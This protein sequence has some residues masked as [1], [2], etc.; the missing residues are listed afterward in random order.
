MI[1]RLII[2]ELRL[3][4]ERE[5]RKPLILRGAR[6]VGKTTLVNEFSKEYGVFLKLNLEIADD[7]NLFERYDKIEELLQAIYVYNHQI[8]EELP[9]L[10]FIDEIQNSP[11]AVAMLRYFNE[12]ANQIHV[13]AAGSLLESLLN[14]QRISFPVGRV[15]YMAM[16]P[17]N[18]LEF[19]NG[20]GEKFDADLIQTI[21]VNAVHER[22]MHLFNSYTLVGGMP[23]AVVQYALNRDI[24]SVAT[25]YE[26][27]LESYREDAEK[28][29]LNDTSEKVIRH[30]LKTGWGSA[31]ETISF[32][33]FGGSNYRSREMGTAF[34]ILE[35]ALLVELVYPT[36]ETKLPILVD[37]RKKP[38][39]IWL[40]TGLVNY[41][42]K[43]QQEV[44]SAPNIQDVWRGRIAEHIVA[45][46][47]LTLD[48]RI[49][50]T[51]NYW[52][53]NKEGSEAEVDF[54]Y[55]Y[56]GKVIPIEIKSGHNARLRS[57]HTFMEHAPHNIA[58][59]VWSQ[60]LSLDIVKTPQGK[61]FKLI[62][63]PFYYIGVLEKVLEKF[64]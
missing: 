5:N 14:T 53:R 56:K 26:S 10:L 59:R 4:K 47:L 8:V 29:A 16:R 40:D 39:I 27:L 15:E 28:Y 61:E 34:R 30:I 38:K 63:L 2:K 25:I 48:T 51:R 32:E 7:R 11:K 6:Q 12:G 21:Q 18:F 24:L 44:F 19:L 50:V 62:N 46:E 64:I 23:A 58:I 31:A 60:Q 52:R 57:L 41:V 42:A 13:I 43:I 36:S 35:K 20:L 1:E 37:Y 45:Q 17:C 3:W 22:V 54:I 33:K 49:S 9:T 55:P